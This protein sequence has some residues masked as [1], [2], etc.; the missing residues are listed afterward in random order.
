MQTLH[1][2]S[3]ST[4]DPAASEAAPAE[5]PTASPMFE[6]VASETGALL[7]VMLAIASA[8]SVAL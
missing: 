8:A 6:S 2:V 1:P 7:A 3:R 5:L 4:P